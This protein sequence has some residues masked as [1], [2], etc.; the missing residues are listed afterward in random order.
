LTIKQTKDIRLAA[1]IIIKTMPG[2]FNKESF[3]KLATDAK[4]AIKRRKN[5]PEI[6]APFK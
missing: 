3:A 1:D 6:A 2:D 4:L 5:P